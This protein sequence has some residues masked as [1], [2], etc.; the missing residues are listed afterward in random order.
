M[1]DDWFPTFGPQDHVGACGHTRCGKTYLLNEKVVKVQTRVLVID[2]KQEDWDHLPAVKW[3]DAIRKIRLSD[4][5]YRNHTT[6]RF[7]W[8]IPMG[9]DEASVDDAGKFAFEAL[10]RLRNV[11]ILWDEIAPYAN[12]NQIQDGIKALI[13]QGGGKDLRF[14]WGSQMPQLTHATIYNQSSHLFVFHIRTKDRKAVKKY[15]PYYEELGPQVPY[16]SYRFIYEDPAGEPR[17]MGP[18]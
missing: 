13:T 16:R 2:T 14:Y 18:V 15:F 1:T 3:P 17:V 11:T 7:R 10:R 4:W 12:A 5:R 9:V 6:A 8:R